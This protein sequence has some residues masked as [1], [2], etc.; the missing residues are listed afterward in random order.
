MGCCKDCTKRYVGCHSKCDSY[1]KE[2]QAWDAAREQRAK[3]K[4]MNYLLSKNKTK[5]YEN[6]LKHKK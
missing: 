1:L 3:T 4:L 6:K 2:K 5:N